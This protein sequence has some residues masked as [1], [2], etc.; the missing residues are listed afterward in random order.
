[1]NDQNLKCSHKVSK[2]FARG[3]SVFESENLCA[4]NCENLR[5]LMTGERPWNNIIIRKYAVICKAKFRKIEIEVF[6]LEK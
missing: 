6:H 2:L 5:I 1:M 3:N 4:I